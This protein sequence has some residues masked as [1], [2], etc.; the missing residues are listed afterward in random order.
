M[1]AAKARG[2]HMGRKPKLTESQL[3]ETH[4]RLEVRES[5]RSSGK[6]LGVHQAMVLGAL[7]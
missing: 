1:K 5:A 7:A 6:I 3:E 4:R 2:A